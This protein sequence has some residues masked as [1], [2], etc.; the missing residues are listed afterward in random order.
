[1]QG[2]RLSI[3]IPTKNRE[4]M[5]TMLLDSIISQN[6]NQETY[7]VLVIDNGSTDSTKE[8]SL[9]YQKNIKNLRYFYDARPGL[10]VGRNKGVLE[11]RGEVIGYLDDDTI[12]FP[13]WIDTILKA[14]EDEEIMGVCG[15]V[16]PYDMSLLTYEFREK[17]EIKI[18][19]FHYVYSISCFWESGI[20]EKDT[21][22]HSTKGEMMFG[23]NCA[24]RKK[25]LY[26]CQGFHPDGMPKKLLMYRGDGE[27]YVTNFL[28]M[29]KMKTIYCAQAS[30]YHQIDIN[31]VD[32]AYLNYMYMRSGISSMY[33][34]LREGGV[35]GGIKFFQNRCKL[36]KILQQGSWHEIQGGMYLFLYYLFYKR[37]RMWVHKTNYF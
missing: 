37:V 12:L 15:S 34:R 36:N 23:G 32:S 13:N 33:T 20:S 5:L 8:V 29:H 1:M 21:R 3:V 28:T 24:Y 25:V 4:K 7:E 22:M 31:R 30:V 11:S 10:H 19:N 27:N 26:A 35:Q 6:V 2:I 14:F 17:Y 18:E 16:I 9:K